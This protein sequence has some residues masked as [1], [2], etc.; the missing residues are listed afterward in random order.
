MDT[1]TSAY[2]D[3]WEPAHPGNLHE[4]TVGV[5]D[6]KHLP[7]PLFTFDFNCVSADIARRA[8][9]VRVEEANVPS[10]DQLMLVELA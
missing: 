5:H 3:A 4:P 2:C 9:D 8:R 7:G 1:S 10:D 6:T